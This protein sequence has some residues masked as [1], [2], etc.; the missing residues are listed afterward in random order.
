MMA[1]L[2]A[3]LVLVVVS[4]LHVARA[5]Q[6]VTV[7]EVKQ[8][9]AAAD[10]KLSHEQYTALIDDL[11]EHMDFRVRPNVDGGPVAVYVSIYVVSFGS[12]SEVDMD[13]SMDVYLREK[14]VDHRLQYSNTTRPIV[15]N[16][17]LIPKM[18]T[19]DLFFPTEKKASFHTVTVPNK[20][21]RIYPNGTVVY[22]MRLTLTLACPMDLTAFPMD[23]QTC[24]IQVESYTL[25]QSDMVLLWEDNDPIEFTHEISLPQF[26]LLADEIID[27]EMHTYK[28]GRFP[29]VK[30]HFMLRRQYGF[31]LLQ[32]YVPTILI[33][34][35][36]WVS[37][38]ISM[39]AVPAR[40]SLGVTTVL[41]MATQLSGSKVSIPRI[42]YPK[43]IDIWMSMCML[44]VFGA[45][46]EYA[47]VNAL[48]RKDKR[49]Q[50]MYKKTDSI[51][52]TYKDDEEAP[53]EGNT[54]TKS[55]KNIDPFQNIQKCMSRRETAR[56]VDKVAR[57][58]FPLA[59]FIFNLVYWPYFLHSE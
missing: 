32:T 6:D 22:S 46:I 25:D 15:I 1:S 35:I 47:F 18:W 54:F 42:S 43:A 39:D 31:F 27:C 40:I 23:S 44:F 7:E 12:I 17:R 28:T 4:P 26:D 20:L 48:S 3:L 49:R 56:I 13:Y 45:L 34:I 19:P 9:N 14:W 16:E 52:E 30:A 50:S 41:T 11:T 5:L 21:M 36:S 59:F 57:I 55:I 58:T 37:F 33:V 51:E 10:D 8:L 24:D 2:A 29:C 53:P 38:W